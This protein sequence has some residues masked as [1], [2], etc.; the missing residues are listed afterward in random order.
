MGKSTE[1][2][3]IK[4]VKQKIK[5]DNRKEKKWKMGNIKWEI[6]QNVEK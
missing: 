3:K 5:Q 4:N 2:R 6:E 1:N